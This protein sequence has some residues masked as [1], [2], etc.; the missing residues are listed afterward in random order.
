MIVKK[1]NGYYVLS[2]KSKRSL[3]GPYVTKAA[4]L[5]RLREIE[6]FREKKMGV[7]HRK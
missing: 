4:A 2:E 7:V 1:H 6:Y 3:G 5:N